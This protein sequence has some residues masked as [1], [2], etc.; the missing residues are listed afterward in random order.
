MAGDELKKNWSTL[1]WAPIFIA[2]SFLFGLLLVFEYLAF[3]ST[4]TPN[5][6]NGAV[7]YS[8]ASSWFGN[9]LLVVQALWGLSFFRDCCKIILT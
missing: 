7:Y 5:L 1:I 9:L 3:S 8:N 2:I 4:G 6:S